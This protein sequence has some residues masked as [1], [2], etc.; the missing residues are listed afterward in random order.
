MKDIVKELR[1]LIKRTCTLYEEMVYWQAARCIEAAD[2]IRDSVAKDINA[3]NPQF[4]LIQEYDEARGKK[5]GEVVQSEHE[6]LSET[7]AT[8]TQ[9]DDALITHCNETGDLLKSIESL[10]NF[11]SPRSA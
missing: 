4:L 9:D 3:D 8:A 6:T 11:E 5:N 7:H 10:I 1:L 2:K